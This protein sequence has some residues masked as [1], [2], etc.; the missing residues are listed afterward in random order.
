[1]RTF[2]ASFNGKIVGQRT[3]RDRIYTHA[4]IVVDVPGRHKDHYYAE[5]KDTRDNRASFAFHESIANGTYQHMQLQS[6][7]DITRSQ[8]IASAGYPAY[9]AHLRGLN[10]ALYERIQA[11]LNLEPHVFGWSMSQDNADKMASTAGRHGCRVVGIVPAEKKII[12]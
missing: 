11:G 12:A 3:S 8:L 7:E 5:V 10:I 9:L 1:M 4:V 2:T 6:A